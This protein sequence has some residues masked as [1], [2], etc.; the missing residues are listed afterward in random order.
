MNIE[1]HEHLM[2]VTVDTFKREA[3]KLKAE[4]AKEKDCNN[5]LGNETLQ[6]THELSE[7]HDANNR[8][9]LAKA[10]AVAD[11]D[12]YR[13]QLAKCESDLELHR[14][15]AYRL[16]REC[17]DARAALK[18]AGYELTPSGEWKPPL[19]KRPDF[20][21]VDLIAAAMAHVDAQRKLFD[22][23]D[24]YKARPK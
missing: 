9:T 7:L 2:R 21:G 24:E 22:A 4:L 5:A 6:L 20:E 11:R 16:A 14:G 1:L 13:D 18:R 19:G 3:D 17:I 15:N 23:A 12:G 8:L 10:L